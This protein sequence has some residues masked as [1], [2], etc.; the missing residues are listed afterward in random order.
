MIDDALLY[1]QNPHWQDGEPYTGLLNR[2]ALTALIDRI[3]IKE[4]LIIPGIRRCGKSTLL[5]LLINYLLKNH[6]SYGS[7]FYINFDDPSFNEIYTEP[8]KLYEIIKTAEK[9]TG[10]KIKYLFLDEI[11]NVQ[12][13]ERFVKSVYDSGLFK[14]ICIT[15]SN[16]TL[17]L[18]NYAKLLTGRYLTVPAYPL[19]LTEILSA[20]KLTHKL[21]QL[22]HQAKILKT[23]EE[24]NLYGSFPEIFAKTQADLK[25]ETLIS[26]YEA[27]LFKDCI[28]N[29]EIRDTRTFKALANYLLTHFATLYS[30]NQLAKIYECSDST[31]KDFIHAMENS[32]MIEE[33]KLFDFSL[34]RQEKNKKKIYVIDNGLIYAA[35]FR[36]S[37]NKGRFLENLV[38][39]ELK[40]SGIKEVYYFH[41]QRECDFIIKKDRK[42][43]AIQVC[44]QLTPENREREIDGLQAAISKLNCDQGYLITFSQEEAGAE[45]YQIIPFWKFFVDSS[46][47]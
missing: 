2:S 24:M 8:K 28:A 18:G 7:I 38:Y 39:T 36:F 40:K 47:L 41:D 32:Y 30:Y 25:R 5:K 35:A 15:G 22:S 44:Y 34:K 21:T 27:I 42:L 45:N 43:T 16:A 20:L 26:Y 19:S 11:Q 1:Q 10:E 14:K 46:Y 37:E 23:I 13:W 4:I 9:I 33:I 31:I 17:L 12:G 29:H 6:Q 3:E